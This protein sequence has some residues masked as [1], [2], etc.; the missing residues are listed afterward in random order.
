MIDN[1]EKLESMCDECITEVTSKNT[2]SRCGKK[3]SKTD[4]FINP[5]FDINKFNK[6]SKQ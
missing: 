5:N 3:I 6:L 4:S 2:C 1:D